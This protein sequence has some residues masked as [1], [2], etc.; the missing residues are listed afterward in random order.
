MAKLL[1]KFI[2]FTL[3][4][5]VQAYAAVPGPWEMGSTQAFKERK[6]AA[7]NNKNDDEIFTLDDDDDLE[8]EPV[9]VE[10]VDYKKLKNKKGGKIPASDTPQEYEIIEP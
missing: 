1:I 2:L 5:A 3:V 6:P 8:R 10:E 9:M 4:L 7:E